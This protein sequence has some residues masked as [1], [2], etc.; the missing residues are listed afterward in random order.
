MDRWALPFGVGP[1]VSRLIAPSSSSAP[2]DSA[3]VCKAQAK[4]GHPIRRLY[5][6]DLVDVGRI[7]RPN[8]NRKINLQCP[9]GYTPRAGGGLCSARAGMCLREDL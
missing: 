3:A 1:S 9:K 2:A 4:H 7:V 8:S 6:C 5:W